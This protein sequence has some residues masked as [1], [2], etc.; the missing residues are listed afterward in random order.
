MVLEVFS[1]LNSS[2]KKDFS[3]ARSQQSPWPA[4]SWRLSVCLRALA[5][6]PDARLAMQGRGKRDCPQSRE[7]SPPQHQGGVQPLGEHLGKHSGMCGVGSFEPQLFYT[8][9]SRV[10]VL[11]SMAHSTLLTAPVVPRQMFVQVCKRLGPDPG[12]VWASDPLPAGGAVSV[13]FSLLALT[14]VS[15]NH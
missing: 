6:F 15:N 13:P 3:A 10:L 8:V 7:G 11:P 4:G 1:N 9:L 5:H 2:V 14:L 12:L